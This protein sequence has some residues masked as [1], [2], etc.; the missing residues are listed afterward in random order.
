MSTGPPVQRNYYK[1]NPLRAWI[2]V[3]LIDK[4]GNTLEV[5][6]I[7][8]S[9]NPYSLIVGEVELTSLSHRKGS[10]ATTNFGI[11]TGGWIRIAIPDIGYDALVRGYG[12]NL[13]R[14]AARQS[15]PDFQGVVG[16][17]LLRSLLYGGDPGS[18]W[19]R[20]LTGTP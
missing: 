19:I 1:G 4:G 10:S 16:L 7:A 12:S 17:P 20:P 6:L 5:D 3:H 8:D 13:I 2:H 11:L 9:G 18:F 14:D 15:H